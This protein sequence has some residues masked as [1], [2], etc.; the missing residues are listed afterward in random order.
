MPNPKDD[1]AFERIIT[2]LGDELLYVIYSVPLAKKI[3]Q[4]YCQKTKY[5]RA[6]F[7]ATGNTGKNFQKGHRRTKRLLLCQPNFYD[8]KRNYRFAFSN[9][10]S[11][12]HD[13][14]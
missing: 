7:D 6:Q 9:M 5:P 10:I 1:Y 13:N 4:H 12:V 14:I 8:K 3:Y 2:F 11:E